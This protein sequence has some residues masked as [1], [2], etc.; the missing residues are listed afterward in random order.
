MHSVTLLSNN[1]QTSN[2]KKTINKIAYP[3]HQLENKKN[4]QNFPN[5]M[6]HR[7]RT[8]RLRVSN[9]NRTRS[10]LKAIKNVN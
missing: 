6:R 2:E 10:F 1:K 3:K 7:N 5:G 4:T 8:I 9:R